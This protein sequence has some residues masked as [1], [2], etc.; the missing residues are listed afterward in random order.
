[1]SEDPIANDPDLLLPPAPE[2]RAEQRRPGR[3]D[4]VCRVLIRPSFHL[5]HAQLADLCSRGVGLVLPCQLECGAIL[6]LQFPR[7][8][9]GLSRIQSAR[10][11]HVRESPEQGWVHGCVLG[12]PLSLD[13]LVALT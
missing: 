7:V 9:K 5:R 3:A 10:V 8:R 1:M 6:A 13:E 4:C 11:V 2:R 12:V